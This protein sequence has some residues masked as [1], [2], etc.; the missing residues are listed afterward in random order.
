MSTINGLP[1]HILLVHAIV[2]LVPLTALLV[3]L[4]AFWPAART[5]LVWPTLVLAALTT[6]LTP[7]T[8]EAGEWLEHHVDRSPAV[9]THTELGDSMVFFTA[10]LF[11]AAIAV[12]AVY[13]RGRTTTPGRTL[14][15]AVAALA[16]VAGVAATVQV[17]RVGESGA[18]ASWSDQVTAGNPTSGHGD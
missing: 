10:A 3:V 7:L 14:T 2:V 1:A 17:Y 6:A 5:R 16:V 9:H 8:T 15:G 4:C 12:A 18:R 11:V 13:V